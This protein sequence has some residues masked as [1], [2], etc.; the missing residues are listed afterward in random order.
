VLATAPTEAQI[1]RKA[2]KDEKMAAL[3][4][5]RKKL[6]LYMKCGDKWSVVTSAPHKS[7]FILWRKCGKS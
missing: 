1:P 2:Q 7:H 5:Q 3:M 6:G 4:T